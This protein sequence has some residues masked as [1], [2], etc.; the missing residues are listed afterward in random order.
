MI[1]ANEVA[2]I[3]PTQTVEEFARNKDRIT[4]DMAAFSGITTSQKLLAG[5]NRGHRLL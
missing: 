2:L 5:Q 3:L 1:E 4:G